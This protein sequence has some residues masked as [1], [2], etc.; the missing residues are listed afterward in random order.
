MSTPYDILS[1]NLKRNAEE[2]AYL[3]EKCNRLRDRLSFAENEVK[4]LFALSSC[5]ET[6][7]SILEIAFDTWEKHHDRQLLYREIY[8]AGYCPYCHR[9]NKD[10]PCV[11][12]FSLSAD[13]SLKMNTASD[14]K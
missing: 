1:L 4:I 10:C 6:R 7:R 5:S 12:K 3:T 8:I 13:E 2:I 14:T 11:I 9:E